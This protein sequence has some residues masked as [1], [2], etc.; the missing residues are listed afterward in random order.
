MD[1]LFCFEK[2]VLFEKICYKYD[3]GCQVMFAIVEK[4]KGE[5]YYGKT[6]NKE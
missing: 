1:I 2:I 5:L 6:T 3:I 4:N